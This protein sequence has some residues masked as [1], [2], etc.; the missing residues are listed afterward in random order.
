MKAAFVNDVK[1]NEKYLGDQYATLCVMKKAD[2]TGNLTP[3]GVRP[4]GYRRPY[5]CG[6]KTKRRRKRRCQRLEIVIT[7][8]GGPRGSG[9]S[10]VDIVQYLEMRRK[11]RL[12]SDNLCWQYIGQWWLTSR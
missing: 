2:S 10:D 6:E 12:V 5:Q 9:I 11:F 8:F 3:N 7:V 1:C 4:Y